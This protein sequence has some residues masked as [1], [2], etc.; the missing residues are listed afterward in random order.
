MPSLTVILKASTV[1]LP[2][3]NSGTNGFYLRRL[4]VV[5]YTDIGSIHSI[6]NIWTSRRFI[7]PEIQTQISSW[8]YIKP[9]LKRR[10]RLWNM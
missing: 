1:L 7:A 10:Y 3:Q 5:D 2:P 8:Y 4:V 6:S 9:V